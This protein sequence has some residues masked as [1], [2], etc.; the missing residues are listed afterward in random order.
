M[1]KFTHVDG[2]DKGKVTLFALSTCAGAK[3]PKR[4]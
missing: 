4:S 2:V 1:I 3:R